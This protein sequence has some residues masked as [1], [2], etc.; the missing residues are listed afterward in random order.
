MWWMRESIFAD[1]GRWVSWMA[2]IIGRVVA[3]TVWHGGAHPNQSPA[4][5][6]PCVWLP[7]PPQP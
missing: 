3:A 6:K 1:V 2:G 5:S 4:L 7:P